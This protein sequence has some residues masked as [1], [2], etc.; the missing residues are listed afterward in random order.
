M[1]C[2]VDA[3][4]QTDRNEIRTVEVNGIMCAFLAYTTLTNGLKPPKGK[5]YYVNVYDAEAVRADV[6]IVSMHWGDERVSTPTK[7]Q[8]EIAERLAKLGVS[9]MAS[10]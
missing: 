8:T 5:E 9:Q 4:R 1:L 3:S 7:A 6:I 2:R 10:I